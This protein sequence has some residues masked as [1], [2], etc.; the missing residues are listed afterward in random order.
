MLQLFEQF[1]LEIQYF[2]FKLLKLL[3]NRNFSKKVTLS[4]IFSEFMGMF[5]QNVGVLIEILYLDLI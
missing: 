3:S 2:I 4:C 5:F 1:N